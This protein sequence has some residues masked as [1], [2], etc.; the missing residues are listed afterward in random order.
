MQLDS[1]TV[2]ERP[3]NRTTAPHVL[4]I[5]ATSSFAF[6]DIEQGIE[7]FKNIESGHV[8]SRY[9]NPTVDTVAAKIADLETHGLGLEASAV[10]TSSGMSAISTLLLGVLKSGD[11]ILTQ[12]NL[13]GGT[14]EL[15][16]AVFGQ[17]G[18]ETVLVD[19]RDLNRVEEVLKND[20][21][22]KLLYCE[23]PANPTLACVDI[24]ALAELAHRHGA[25]CAID[26]TFSTPLLQQPFAHGV[27]FIIH[28]T[29][30]YLNGHGNSTAGV[31]LGLDKK[32]M[33]QNVWRAMKLAGTNCSPFEAW[34]THNG[35]KT[36]AL[37]ME[38]HSANALALAEFLEKHPA[39]KRV[40]YPGLPSHPDHELAK[41][42][43][44]GGYGGMLSFEL[45]GGLEAG[46]QCMNRIK[47]CTLA[48][49]LGDVDTLILHPASSSH[50]AIP[51]EIR[52]QNGITDGM[53]R[54]SVGIE[55]A[56]DIIGDLRQAIV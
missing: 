39:V 35:L 6:E 4:P 56:E 38:R 12:G 36:L 23:T 40:N 15:L 10:M 3:D 54:V 42:Q 30:K 32:M 51:K 26:N 14:T 28:S 21:K 53:I 52:L 47:F 55:N 48:P 46:I 7:I 44:R 13:Y 41:R 17:F 50:V 31:I 33:R 19:L 45:K 5:Y 11:K 20:K 24:R 49:T 18:V 2:K 8:Y 16:T 29:T 37:R 1:L 34:L 25:F 27:D 43:M 22:I 9:A